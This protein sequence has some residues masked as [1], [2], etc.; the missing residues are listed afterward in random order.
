VKKLLLAGMAALALATSA[1]AAQIYAQPGS[2]YSYGLTKIVVQGQIYEGDD[3]T[4]KAL[5]D[6][7]PSGRA[8]VVLSRSPGGNAVTAMNMGSII[9]QKRFSTMLGR[10]TGGYCNSACTYI[11]LAGAHVSVEKGVLLGFHR[12]NIDGQESVLGTALVGIYLESLGLNKQQIQW[13]L[14]APPDG[15]RNAMPMD[16]WRLGF[17]PQVVL[18]L[19][20]ACNWQQC[21]SRWCY[22][23]P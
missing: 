2:G 23:T 13:M 12:P 6:Q 10:R 19:F 7:I 8:M 1:N 3:Q 16:P 20:G 9:Q 4:F 11:L 17:N 21:Q 18:G 14:S 22:I 15:I 5:A